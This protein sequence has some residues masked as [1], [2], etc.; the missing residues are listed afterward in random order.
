MCVDNIAILALV[1]LVLPFTMP[2]PMEI[3]GIQVRAG[4]HESPV[5][6]HT[7]RSVRSPSHHGRIPLRI[8]SI[9]AHLCVCQNTPFSD[10]NFS[11]L[12]GQL[13]AQYL[14]AHE[15]LGPNFKY[16]TQI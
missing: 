9:F 8:L 12:C 14:Y 6:S 15:E 2:W 13:A 5:V 16:C 11:P 1:G 4:P 3:F 10:P 7:E